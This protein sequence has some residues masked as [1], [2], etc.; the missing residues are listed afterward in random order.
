MSFRRILSLAALTTVVA[1]GSAQAGNTEG[2]SVP[3]Y[4]G[5]TTNSLTANNVAAGWGNKAKQSVMADQSGTYKSWPGV[6]S[7]SIDAT[8]LAAGYGNKAKQNIMSS[9]SGGGVPTFNSVDALNMAVGSHN[10][11]GQRLMTR[12][13]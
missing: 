12:Q 7:N 6:T 10:F 13:R 2:L 5:L 1:I 9:Q 8:N 11:A 3:P 4:G